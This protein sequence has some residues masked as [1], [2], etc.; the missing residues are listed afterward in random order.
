MKSTSS[1]PSKP[2]LLIDHLD[3]LKLP[4]IKSQHSPLADQAAQ[5]HWDHVDYMLIRLVPNGNFSPR[6]LRAAPSVV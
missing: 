2:S 6:Q 3:Y 5:Q 4:F 1:K